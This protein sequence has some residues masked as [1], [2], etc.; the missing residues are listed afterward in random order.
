M[1]V[2]DITPP[3]LEPV[4]L[5]RAKLFL[6]VEHDLEDDLIKDM[7]QAARLAVENYTGS[8]LITRERRVYIYPS[9][10]SLF[11]L[12]HRPIQSI[13]SLNIIRR[14]GTV[15]A[16]LSE[17]YSVNLRANPSQI[18]ITDPAILKGNDSHIEIDIIA[19]YGL[20]GTDIPTPFIQAMLLMIAQFYERQG[21]A[22]DDLPMMVQALLMPYR[23]LRL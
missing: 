9:C 12:S 7:I 13:Q 1:D 20:S 3:T 6:R 8:S 14:D 15:V 17:Q 22:K 16:L 5:E 10:L 4:S 2:V 19:G 11:S 21:T 23:G 18:K